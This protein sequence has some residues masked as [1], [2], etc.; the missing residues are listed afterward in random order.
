MTKR[1]RM[2][3]CGQECRNPRNKCALQPGHSL[4]DWIRLGSSGK[5]LT[6]VGPKAGHLSVSSDTDAYLTCS[7]RLEYSSRRPRRPNSVVGDG[8]KSESRQLALRTCL[9]SAQ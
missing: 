2:H 8:S 5:D 7:K 3:N 6:G 1:L 4:M 9:G